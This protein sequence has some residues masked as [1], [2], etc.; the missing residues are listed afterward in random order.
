LK[1]KQKWLSV[2]K[3]EDVRIIKQ[4]YSTAIVL[5]SWLVLTT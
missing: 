3:E 1:N 5:V 4:R 2:A